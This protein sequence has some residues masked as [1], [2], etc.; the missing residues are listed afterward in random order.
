MIEFDEQPADDGGSV[1]LV[2][3]IVAGGAAAQEQISAWLAHERVRVD[4]AVLRHGAVLIRGFERLA[5]AA[6]FEAVSGALGNGTMP[7][8]GGTSPRRAV[9]GN[10]MTATEVPR[11]YSIPLHQEMS[12]TEHFPPRIAF[13]CVTP[14]ATGGE[15]TVAD[16]R[17]V[18]RRI[19]PAV[20]ARIAERGLQLRRNLP[21][22]EYVNDRPGVPKAW[23][24]VFATDDRRLAER[25]ATERGWRTEWLADGSLQLWQEVLPA[26][27]RHP[28]THDLVWFNQVHIFSPHAALR[29]ARRDGRH[30]LAG[31]LERALV[32]HPERLDDVCHGDGTPLDRDDVL[33][34]AD[35]LDAAARPVRWQRGDLLLLD[36]VL[37]GH[38]RRQ[39]EGER[40]ILT[41]L[42]GTQAAG[43]RHAA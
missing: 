14:A 22:P 41:A 27:R 3:R 9:R 4:A 40:L 34:V 39:F 21:L 28:L 35:V 2:W 1:P 29:W 7:Y 25:A 26:M 19:D 42:I 43:Q 12:Y 33:H 32:E 24:E 20:R 16:M 13:L 30:A 37:G 38:G 31:R 15:T 8:I 36:N 10:I 18:T 11:D 17:D 5:N 23:T 6:A